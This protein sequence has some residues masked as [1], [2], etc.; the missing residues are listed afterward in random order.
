MAADLLQF[1]TIENHLFEAS[2]NADTKRQWQPEDPWDSLQF[3]T[4]AND[5][6]GEH[7][8]GYEE[9]MAADLLQF[10]TIANHLFW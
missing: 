1:A 3:A 2:I 10:A 5:L 8:C 4:V 7:K 6:R 9:A